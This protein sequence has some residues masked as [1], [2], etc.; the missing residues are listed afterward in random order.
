METDAIQ[1]QKAFIRMSSILKLQ[2]FYDATTQELKEANAAVTTPNVQDVRSRLAER[3]SSLIKV[4]SMLEL[5][6]D[7]QR[8]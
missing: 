8:V 1:N 2:R 4:I 3:R 7:T 5:P 6:I